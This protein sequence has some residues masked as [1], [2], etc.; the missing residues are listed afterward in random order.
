MTT[1]SHNRNKKRGPSS[2]TL[3]GLFAVSVLIVVTLL[4]RGVFSGAAM[5][6]VMP[7]S[8]VR[9]VSGSMLAHIIA[10]FQSNSALVA[11]NAALQN[12]LASTTA[13]LA[14]RDALYAEVLDLKARLNRDATLKTTLAAIVSRPPQTPY[15]LLLVDAGS[16]Q[17]VAAGDIVAA[18]GTTVIGVVSEVFGNTSR[19]ALF[20]TPGQTYPA[21]VTLKDGV[22]V[23]VSIEGQG[24][25]SMTGQVP[26]G[27]D[28]AAG[29]HVVFPSVAGGFV[30]TVSAVQVVQNQS[31]ITI[32][33]H[34]PVSVDGL[35]FVEIW[36]QH[37]Q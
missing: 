2:T 36:T 7:A 3:V 13:A 6:T 12:E 32:Y 19:V 26:A 33:M 27:T 28:I 31:F 21:L 25:G 20:S 11:Q 22:T 17:G 30:A 8:V 18:G 10:G 37:A 4:W 34:M 9:T 15:D 14:D 29:D 16:K 23:P 24:A 1:I 5:A 35:R